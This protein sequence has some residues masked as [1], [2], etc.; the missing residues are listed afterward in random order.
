[1]GSRRVNCRMRVSWALLTQGTDCSLIFPDIPPSA[2][3]EFP[4]SLVFPLPPPRPPTRPL[5]H[6][7][8]RY[9]RSPCTSHQRR[10]FPPKTYNIDTPK[11]LQPALLAAGVPSAQF[12]QPGQQAQQSVQ[13]LPMIDMY[14]YAPRAITIYLCIQ[15][16]RHARNE[17]ETETRR[18]KKTKCDKKCYQGYTNA[19]KFN[20]PKHTA[21]RFKRDQSTNKMKLLNNM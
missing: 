4:P 10:I 13:H 3:W 20:K 9:H 12:G 8:T 21:R 14:I 1:M 2:F 11:Q 7:P 15:F 6:Q 18:E 16:N 17:A 5:A 19:T